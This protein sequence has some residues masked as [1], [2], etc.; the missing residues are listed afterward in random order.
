MDSKPTP[1]KI[2]LKP[3]HVNLLDLLKKEYGVSS[4]SKVLE[5]LL[6]DLLCTD[7]D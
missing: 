6:D 5:M 4:K 1:V 2:Y 7:G 3:E